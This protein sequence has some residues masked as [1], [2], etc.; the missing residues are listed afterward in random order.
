[1]KKSMAKRSTVI[2][3]SASLLLTTLLAACSGGEKTTTGTKDGAAKPAAPAAEA[4]EETINLNV[5]L[6]LFTSIPPTPDNQA[7]KILEEKTNAK[8]DFNLVPRAN[9]N[10]KLNAMIAGNDLPKLIAALEIRL[11]TIANA[12]R[13]GMFWEIGPHLKNY[14][15][16]SRMNP[17]IV[18]ATSYDGKVY[19][20]YRERDT[21]KSGVIVRKDWL[22]ALG[23]KVPKT[24]KELYEVAKAFTQNDPDKNGKNDTYGISD[25]KI[26]NTS[27]FFSFVSVWHGAPAG[28]G[29]DNGKLVADIQTKEY[30][31]ALK[32][33]RQL[34]DEK[35]INS[36]FLL[37]DQKVAEDN[38]VKGKAG[39]YVDDFSKGPA[40]LDEIK[41]LHPNAE[42]TYIPGIGTGD[43]LRQ[44]GS[45]GHFGLLMIP[46]TSVKTE[47]E[48]KRILKVLDIISGEQIQNLLTWGIEGKHY[49]LEGGKVKLLDA[50]ARTDE[51]G[52]IS[53]IKTMFDKTYTAIP[54]NKTDEEHYAAL[55]ISNAAA[56]INVA[57][58]LS[59]AKNDEVG[60]TIGKNLD[61]AKNKFFLKSIDEAGWSKAVDDWLKAGGSEIIK[62]FQEGYDK[63]KK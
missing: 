10:D 29:V 45:E 33:M 24:P 46:K 36:D 59:S 63:S 42:L 32:F 62:Q 61:D 20:V 53:Q 1:M 3:L 48:M 41:K 55:K 8:F 2:G 35:L 16:L 18:A 57:A 31:E 58:S 38:F 13:S 39:M 43:K 23:L 11:P 26:G 14:P 21:A 12:V 25:R 47:A 4:K 27:H 22:D 60:A 34:V 56:V 5:L 19:G 49:T 30:A 37:V 54:R 52:A 17:N 7:V 50:K 15:N 9:Y 44:P 51:V 6:P 40:M 28:Y